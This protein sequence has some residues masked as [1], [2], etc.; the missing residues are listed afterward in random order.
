MIPV[1]F[2][3]ASFPTTPA[4]YEYA[5]TPP[6]D[7][8][9]YFNWFDRGNTRRGAPVRVTPPAGA[10]QC[11]FMFLYEPSSG[12]LPTPGKGCYIDDLVIDAVPNDLALTTVTSDP[13][14]FTITASAGANGS[15]DPDGDVSVNYGDDQGFTI[16]PDPGYAIDDVLVDGVS[17]PGAVAAGSYTFTDVTGGH[18]ISA[19]FKSAEKPVGVN[20]RSVL[21]DDKLVG[22]TV[23]AWGNVKSVNGTTSFTIDDG[24]GT[25]VTVLVNG[26]SL[27]SG[28]DTTKLAIV[29]GVVNS[30]KT[31]R[32]QAISAVP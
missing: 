31:I 30:D 32:A 1:T 5:H 18:T 11:Y 4:Y 8:H 26:V 6:Y 28:F 10:T 29:T 21:T 22:R 17:N 7:W 27:P 15:I 3:T 25:P 13:I 9:S 24:Y 12:I 16:T 14:T 20:N 2:G 23:R 19:T